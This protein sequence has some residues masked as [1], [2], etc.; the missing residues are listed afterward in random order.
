M[1]RPHPMPAAATVPAGS[2]LELTLSQVLSVAQTSTIVDSQVGQLLMHGCT[3]SAKRT[4][5]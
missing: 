2:Q 1:P 3:G 4:G 5:I